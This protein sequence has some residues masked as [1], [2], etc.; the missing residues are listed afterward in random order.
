MK[1]FKQWVEMKLL[2][3]DK[4]GERVEL[5]GT[6]PLTDYD[7]KVM[8]YSGMDFRT[9]LDVCVSPQYCF[10]AMVDNPGRVSE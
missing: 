10:V 4:S 2:S 8:H 9:W 1:D 7:T 3:T 5:H 6:L